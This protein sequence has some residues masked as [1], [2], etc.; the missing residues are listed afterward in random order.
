MSRQVCSKCGQRLAP[1]ALRCSNGHFQKKVRKQSKSDTPNAQTSESSPK[2]TELELGCSRCGRTFQFTPMVGEVVVNCPYCGKHVSVTGKSDAVGRK[3]TELLTR[4][5]WS[6]VSWLRILLSP[7][8]PEVI[9]V[10]IALAVSIPTLVAGIA[11]FASFPF[12]LA[13]P[14]IGLV[15]TV[16][17]YLSATVCG[18]AAGTPPLETP[19]ISAWPRLLWALLLSALLVAPNVIVQS[20][21]ARPLGDLSPI[22]ITFSDFALSS[23]ALGWYAV[24]GNVAYGAFAST[25][26]IDGADLFRFFEAILEDKKWA[27]DFAL[28]AA[29]TMVLEGVW[30]FYALRSLNDAGLLNSIRSG[31]LDY[32][33]D[34]SLRTILPIL[35][36]NGI[37]QAISLHTFGLIMRRNHRV[38]GYRSRDWSSSK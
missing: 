5:S 3:A 29:M 14:L 15:N 21:L 28:Q 2:H 34:Q 17:F 18:R 26:D 38:L 32:F 25:N 19:E 12:G 8:M 37:T 31:T 7:I 13:L 11:V 23:L 1:G 16:G 30:L 9:I 33:A 36:M 35:A 24:I 22:A 4:R 6:Q 27:C 20:K 10:E